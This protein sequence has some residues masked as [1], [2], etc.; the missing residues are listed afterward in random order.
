MSFRDRYVK[1]PNGHYYDPGVASTCPQCAQEQARRNKIGISNEQGRATE[2]LN[3]P[4][5]VGV[6]E[7]LNGQ[8]IV[9]VTEPLNTPGGIGATVPLDGPNVV[10]PAEPVAGRP[11]PGVTVPLA[12]MKN[13]GVKVSVEA[14]ADFRQGAGE[15]RPHIRGSIEEFGD[16]PTIPPTVPVGEHQRTQAIQWR[17]YPVVG[18]L[19]CIEGPDRGR[20][21]NIHEQYNFIGRSPSMDIYLSDGD[22]TISRERHAVIAYDPEE[23]IFYFAPADGR[24]LV[25]VNGKLVMN[26][27]E[28][29]AYDTLSMGKSKF[30]FVPFC[31]K[32]FSWDDEN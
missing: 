9:G 31:G 16:Q 26:Q 27:H 7:P 17:Q 3:G 14:Q 28:L 2:A 8:G 20:S 11:M 10:S 22:L 32:E 12:G 15:R 25:R 24:G 1:C 13:P 19:V 18:W 4:G 23:K 21:F 5:I 6:T 29:K 30:K